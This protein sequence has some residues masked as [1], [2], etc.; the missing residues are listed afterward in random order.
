MRPEI[1]TKW[2]DAIL[3]Y[4]ESTRHLV[5]R[6]YQ[7][8]EKKAWKAI[9][10]GSFAMLEL[11]PDAG[12]IGRIGLGSDV[13]EAIDNRVSPRDCVNGARRFLNQRINLSPPEN[14]LWGEEKLGPLA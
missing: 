6:E 11:F 3:T 7:E 1:A 13:F 14:K 4:E 2:N 10:L 12:D 8:A 9:R 5:N